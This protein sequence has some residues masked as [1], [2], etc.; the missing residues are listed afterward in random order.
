MMRTAV[1][2]KLRGRVGGSCR[3]EEEEGGGWGPWIQI[4]ELNG[5]IQNRLFIWGVGGHFWEDRGVGK[6]LWKIKD[7]LSNILRATTY[8][9][10]GEKQ[11]QNRAKK[12]KKK[13]PQ[14]KPSL[15]R[16]LPQPPSP[17]QESNPQPLRD[18]LFV[19]DGQDPPFCL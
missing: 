2:Q 8:S 4:G 3:S 17:P 7:I 9:V 16:R 1:H 15:H 6:L 18:S 19:C 5:R 11:G 10:L 13:A 12:H 14:N